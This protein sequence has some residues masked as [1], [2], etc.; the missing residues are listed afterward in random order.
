VSA[1]QLRGDH[2]LIEARTQLLICAALSCPADVRSDCERKVEEVNA[3]LPTVVFEA[4]DASGA[5]LSGVK[6]AM[7]GQPLVE[8]L[9]GT[10]ITVNPGEH[11]FTFEI[12][13]QPPIEKTIVLN[14]GEKDRHESVAVSAPKPAEALAEPPPPVEHGSDLVITTEDAASVAID[15]RVVGSGRFHDKIAPGPHHVRVTELGKVPYESDIDLRDGQPRTLDVTLQDEKRTLLW[16]WVAGGA[17]V[18]AAAV[19]GG[20][21]LFKQTGDTT[22]PPVCPSCLGNMQLSSVGRRGR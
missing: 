21:F 6:V 12:A 14:E 13:G 10:A 8:H 5:D 15:G 9:D 7:D 16:P 17:V 1:L 22:S 18:V 19:V 11:R 2:K 3:A 4:K 20:Y